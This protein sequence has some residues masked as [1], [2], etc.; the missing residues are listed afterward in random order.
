MNRKSKKQLPVINIPKNYEIY[1]L[2]DTDDSDFKEP[3][4]QSEEVEINFERDNNGKESSV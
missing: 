1:E 2:L 3:P 4:I